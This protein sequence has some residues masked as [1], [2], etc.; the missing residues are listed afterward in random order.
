MPTWDTSNTE[1]EKREEGGCCNFFS[2]V[3]AM[4]IAQSVGKTTQLSIKGSTH[5]LQAK[6]RKGDCKMQGKK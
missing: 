2:S 4:A 3:A 6:G 1:L 5:C